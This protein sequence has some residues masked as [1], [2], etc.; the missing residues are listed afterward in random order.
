MGIV[1]VLKPMP[2]P[3]RILP[4]IM[5]ANDNDVACSMPPRVRQMH[6]NITLLGSLS[7]SVDGDLGIEEL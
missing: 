7:V 1:V 3:D 6:P 2:M 4:M 5:C